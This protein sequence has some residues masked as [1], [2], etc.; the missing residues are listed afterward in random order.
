MRRLRPGAERRDHGGQPGNL[1]RP[2]GQDVGEVVH[3]Q[4]EPGNTY[5]QHQSYTGGD[6]PGPHRASFGWQH[7]QDEHPHRTTAVIA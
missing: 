7:D 1:E 6:Q 2:P 3:A 4:C 5:D